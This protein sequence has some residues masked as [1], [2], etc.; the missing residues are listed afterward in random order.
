MLSIEREEFLETI[1][2]R[3]V[4]GLKRFLE[5][6]PSLASTKDRNGVSAIL[7]AIYYGNKEAADLIAA[8]KPELDV[9]E[10]AS[11]GHLDQRSEEHTSE[12]QSRGHLVCRLLL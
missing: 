5:R 10:A 11:L 12:L 9:F 2:K 3:D 7:V 1:K 4:A 6:E 8:K